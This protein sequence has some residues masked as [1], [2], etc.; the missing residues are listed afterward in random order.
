MWNWRIAAYGVKRVVAAPGGWLPIVFVMTL[1]PMAAGIGGAIW[2][3]VFGWERK[4]PAHSLVR[5]AGVPLD[6]NGAPNA[7]RL[8]ALESKFDQTSSFMTGEVT[9]EG[10]VFTGRFRGTLVSANF[11]D[12]LGFR[13][14]QGRVRDW[15]SNGV[16]LSERAAQRLFGPGYVVGRP[17]RVHG[18]AAV[19]AA[20]LASSHEYPR[21]SDVWVAPGFIDDAFMSEAIIWTH[22]GRLRSGVTL[23]T[24][25]RDLARVLRLEQA[26]A[27]QLI[28]PI[29]AASRR[30]G[31]R[32]AWL[33][34]TAAGTMAGLA[35]ATLLLLLFSRTQADASS[36]ATRVALGAS[37]A[38]LFQE[39]AGALLLPIVVATGASLWL[40]SATSHSIATAGAAALDTLKRVELSIVWWALG[41]VMLVAAAAAS[42]LLALRGAGAPVGMRRPAWMPQ[43]ILVVQVSLAVLLT[44]VGLTVFRTVWEFY[45]TPLGFAPADVYVADINLPRA[46]FATPASR[47]AVWRGLMD[48]ARTVRGTASVAAASSVPFDGR[49]LSLL[50]VHLTQR[51]S[52]PTPAVIRVVSPEFFRILNG[53]LVSGS[54]FTE[55][56][57][58]AGAGG[59][60]CLVTVSLVSPHFRTATDAVGTEIEVLGK[61]RR[62]VGVVG[63]MALTITQERPLPTVY[64]PLALAPPLRMTLVAKTSEPTLVARALATRMRGLGGE[65]PAPLLESFEERIGR[66][67]AK[68]RIAAMVIGGLA[69]LGMLIVIASSHAV[70]QRW[71]VNRRRD[72]GVRLA[73]GATRRQLTS[74]LCLT[75]GRGVAIGLVTGTI[76]SLAMQ[77]LLA[78]QL[79]AGMSAVGPTDVLAACAGVLAGVTAANWRT[80]RRA[81]LDSPAYLLRHG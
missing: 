33:S 1:L 39:Q 46:A 81:F 35:I 70:T 19:V 51:R 45:R 12:V 23:P 36:Y 7:A 69:V 63:D 74:W 65:V 5:F 4:L 13:G 32:I 20:V 42:T 50:P 34:A 37:R 2:E 67:V 6:A 76:L 54:L 68:E 22:I 64:L 78:T 21:E 38:H 29:Q 61:R 53:R 26:A 24:A 59:D 62:I 73:L 79:I 72:I 10:A 55:S 9:V 43:G 17:L 52:A 49:M 27:L 25:S 75:L 11:V 80:V 14:A 8:Q 48:D 47:M 30:D 16:V 41:I 40:A 44:V 71:L 77:R 3:A 56:L 28:E 66:T 57:T 15:P 58:A 60:V 18:H 31:A